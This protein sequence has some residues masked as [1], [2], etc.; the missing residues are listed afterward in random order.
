[1]FYDRNL[2]S[3]CVIYDRDDSG[4]YNNTTIL[5][6]LVSAKYNHKVPFKLKHTFMIVNI[7][8]T[9]ANDFS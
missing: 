1:M 5:A 2:Q 4:L 8:S 6:N 9:V 3:Y 7:C